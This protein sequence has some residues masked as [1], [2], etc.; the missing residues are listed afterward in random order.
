MLVLEAGKVCPYG[1]NCPYNNNS[2]IS[3]PC[4]GTIP[5][6]KTKFECAFVV[7]GKVIKD[8][9]ARIPGDQTGKMKIIYD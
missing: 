3:T 5:T 2:V 4:L 1:N 8:A 6:R 7:N 9:G